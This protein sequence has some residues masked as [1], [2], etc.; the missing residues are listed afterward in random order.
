MDTRSSYVIIGNGIAG[1]T[2]AEILRTHDAASAITIVADDP[3]PAY[4]R[5]A[6]KDFL[7]GRLPEGKLWARPS[8][9]YQEQHIRFVPGRVVSINSQQHVVQL[10]N[11]RLIP[12]HTLLLA[13][14]ARSHTLSCPGLNL[15]GV[16]TLRTV[17]DYQ[18][19]LRRLEKVNRVVVCGS[20]TLA[21]ESAETLRHCGY[22]VTHLLRGKRLW[23]EVLDPVAS[24]MV[25]QEE[26]RDGVDV[27]VGEEIAEIRGKDGQV[28][29]ILTT[30]GERIAC[31][32]VLIAVGIDPLTDFIRASGIACGRGVQV[33]SC[34]RT[35]SPDIYAAGD[36]I[37]TT[38]VLTGR[39]RILGQWFPA[40][41]QAQI[42]AYHML[43][44]RSP[45][46]I[47]TTSGHFYNATFLYGLDFVS[48][49]LTNCPAAPGF[50]ELIAEPMPRS[51]RK[52]IFYRDT[53]VGALLLGDRRQALAFK[54]AIDQQTNLLPVSRQLFNEGFDLDAWLD[55]Q[56]IPAPI[57]SLQ[58]QRISAISSAGHKGTTGTATFS[59]KTDMHQTSLK[60]T[61]A[62]LVPIP[63]PKVRVFA[64]E[65]Q[66]N[67]DEQT[68]VMTL[69]RQTGV[70]WLLEHSSISRLHA[71]IT[72]ADDA[73]LLR[74]RG[75]SNGTFINGSP[76][77][78]ENSY[79][80][81]SND[82]VRFGDM[83]FRFE[84]RPHVSSSPIMADTSD[85]FAHLPEYGVAREYLTP[86]SHIISAYT[87][88]DAGIGAGGAGHDTSSASSGTRTTL[89]VGTRSTER[90]GFP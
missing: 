89:P 13:N 36:V 75:S 10:H 76:L 15:A 17:A 88:R 56:Q 70:T 42:A 25:L 47:N 24:D 57:L 9:F 77:V 62:Y 64:T 63:H 49:G 23:A 58:T 7:G 66:L 1:V 11:G 79:L 87:A 61:D 82:L 65:I 73:Y 39:T 69:G 3:F 21:L 14:G 6:L 34:M 32:L 78:R 2:A 84:L 81:H 31:E 59:D 8:T 53:I 83:Q 4:Y 52:A 74:D 37:E 68:P 80:L 16:T 85:S 38:D 50:S 55:Q 27:R 90:S 43:G 40:I 60:D 22:Q 29:A 41:Q 71:E 67:R 44:L 33:D 46:A 18:E 54:R 45:E 48:I 28:C 12:Y 51:Y 30:L 26:Q 20:G 35:S 72:R 19:V 86:H 5:P